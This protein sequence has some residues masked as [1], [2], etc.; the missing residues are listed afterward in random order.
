MK[1]IRKIIIAAPVLGILLLAGWGGPALLPE[2][3]QAELKDTALRGAQAELYLPDDYRA[4]RADL[5][6]AGAALAREQQRLFL[7]RDLGP[8]RSEFARLVQRADAL[9]AAMAEKKEGQSEA[10]ARRL[11]ELRGKLDQ[12]GRLTTLLNEGRISRRSITHASVLLA[13][14]HSYLRGAKYLQAEASLRNAQTLGRLAL[15][16]LWPLLE[17]FAD[18]HNIAKWHAWKEETVRE[19]AQTGKYAIVVSK[20]D[21]RLMLYQGGVLVKS[22][23]AAI[24]LNG[25][26]EKRFAGDRA[27]PEGRYHISK[28]NAASAFYRALLIDYPNADDVR[29]FREGKRRGVIGQGA[30]IGGLIEIHGGGVAGMT[31]GCMALQNQPMLELF[32]L[33]GVGTP[34]T[35]VGALNDENSI[36]KALRE[37]RKGK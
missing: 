23:D 1:T 12:V 4:F 25:F 17:R 15:E 34:V 18:A 27:T 3:L 6:G 33:V 37:Y 7:S 11:E 30:R 31:Y 22:Y 2:A 8:V 28:K 16:P 10:L 35:I 13:E 32:S 29:R 21:R 26:S 19:S 36:A 20:I 14:A 5:A 9:L 24:G